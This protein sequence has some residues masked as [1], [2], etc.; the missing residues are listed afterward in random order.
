[1]DK[2][3]Q[4]QVNEAM[5]KTYGNPA[6]FAAAVKKYGFGVAVSAALMSNA[7]AASIDV[8]SVVGTITDGVTTVSSIGLAVLLVVLLLGLLQIQLLKVLLQC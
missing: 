6:A 1:M 3:T 7:N 2:L 8:T 4:D 5:N